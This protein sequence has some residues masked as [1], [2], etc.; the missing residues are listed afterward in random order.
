M[1]D[2]ITYT[3]ISQF[4]HEE[5]RK[6]AGKWLKMVAER[7]KASEQLEGLRKEYSVAKA[8]KKTELAARILPLEQ[9]YEKLIADIHAL[10]KEIRT[11]EQR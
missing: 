5:S 3:T 2:R 6:L 4:R 1:N 9:K 11:F 8:E 10:E 7:N